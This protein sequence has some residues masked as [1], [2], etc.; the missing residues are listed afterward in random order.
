MT[1]L[2]IDPGPVESAV[3]RWDGKRVS[4][5]EKALNEN[6]I[7]GIRSGMLHADS[8]HIEMIASY[9]MPVGR[10]VFDTCVWI[11]RFYET[12]WMARRQNAWLV[13]RQAIKL[14]HCHSARAKDGNIRQALIDKYGKPGTKKNQ[15]VTYD[16]SGDTWQ[17][18]ALA[19]FVT[20]T[21]QTAKQ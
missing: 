18:F 5:A 9:G 19:T 16:L 15:G 4:L 21:I 8:F 10:E 11:G 14:H 7:A 3:V 20:E 2:A 12:W 1:V 17:A 13:Y 6:V